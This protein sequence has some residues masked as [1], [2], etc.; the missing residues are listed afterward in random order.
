MLLKLGKEK[1][2]KRM[3]FKHGAIAKDE[4]CNVW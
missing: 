3:Y 4:M 2:S 1:F